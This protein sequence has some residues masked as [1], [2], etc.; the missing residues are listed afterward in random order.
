MDSVPILQGFDR[1]SVVSL[2]TIHPTK[3]RFSPQNAELSA[4]VLDDEIDQALFIRSGG[5]TASGR[6][7]E[8]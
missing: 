1:P 2:Q 6:S 8:R 3:R 5:A 7:S 4:F